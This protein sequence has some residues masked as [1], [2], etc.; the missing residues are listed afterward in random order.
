MNR[1]MNFSMAPLTPMIKGI[2]ITNVIIWFGLQVLVE[3]FMK[4]PVTMFLA[5]VPADVLFEYNIWR[6]LTYMFTHSLQVTHILFNMLMLWF[7]GH[8]LEELWGSR[9]F[10]LYYLLT[11]VGA[12][13]IYT[14]GIGAYAFV[15]GE[16]RSLIIPVVGASGALYGVMLAYGIL[17][18]E[19]TVYFFMLFPMKA[20]V[21]VFLMGLIEFANMMTSQVLGS[22]V[23]Y[24]AHLGGLISGLFLFWLQR[25]LS[26]R[27][28]RTGGGRRGRHLHL[29]V[30]ND[31]KD[32]G[33]RY[34]N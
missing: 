11:G 15:T 3:G 4:V 9:R 8:E 17:F 6:L 1:S 24:L 5:L 7:F 29:V 34:W 33:P 31:K 30:D 21:F 10:L 2:V 14:M 22:E 12:A 25:T 32:Q 23:A 28:D 19:R 26:Q 13:L 18:G 20:R 16:T 27:R